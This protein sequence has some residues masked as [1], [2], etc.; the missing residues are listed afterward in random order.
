MPSRN[1]SQADFF[2]ALQ[3]PSD[4][5][6]GVGTDD[7][8]YTLDVNGDLNFNGT[9]YKNGIE[10]VS[11]VGIRSDGTIITGAGTTILNFVGSAVSRLRFKCGI[12]RFCL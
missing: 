6:V 12:I 8:N 1:F 3:R 4:G 10:Y 2:C 5:N 9:L 7:P 11:G